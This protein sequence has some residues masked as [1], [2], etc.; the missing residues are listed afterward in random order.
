[1]NTEYKEYWCRKGEI[2]EEA[3]VREIVPRI[4]R[5]LII[6]P[7]KKTTKTYIDLLNVDTNGVA[8]LKTQNTPFFKASMYG[9]DPQ[10][11]VTFNRKDYLNYKKRYPESVIYFWVNW[12]QTEITIR[13]EVY[14][15][16]PLYG[17]WEVNFNEL[18]IEGAPLHKYIRR[19]GDQVN[20][21]ESYLFDLNSFTR[22]LSAKPILLQ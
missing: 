22:L 11:T 2:A 21:T 7:E 13:D 5:N 16:Q 12:E 20:A 9:Y 18:R 10:Y 19:Y 4:N 15:V 3:F 6:H 1:M 8:D 14:S 17:V